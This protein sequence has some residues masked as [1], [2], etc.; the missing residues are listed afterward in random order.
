[1]N[2]EQLAQNNVKLAYWMA[3]RFARQYGVDDKE[4]EA[5][6]LAGLTAAA[7]AYDP[8]RGAK[9]S[10]VAGPYIRNALRRLVKPIQGQRLGRVDLD[11]S[12]GD[13]EGGEDASMHDVVAGGGPS[14]D[15]ER[16]DVFDKV[17]QELAALPDDERQLV[18]RWIAGET[19]R[20][21][22][23]DAGVSFVQVGNI[24][25][26]AIGKLKTQLAGKGITGMD[27]LATEALVK[28]LMG[29]MVAE[30][31]LEVGRTSPPARVGMPTVP[32]MERDRIARIK[33][34]R[35]LQRLTGDTREP[36]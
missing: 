25:R 13:E 9:F 14:T 29:R 26:K 7:N 28:K 24:I 12:F 10:S 8:A 5:Q 20:D 18:S 17:Q 32:E 21:I 6:A 2:P 31:R 15:T 22:A 34:R 1:M 23:D 4:A 16:E 33:R 27:A 3:S 19:Y 35:K 30:S 11:A 36:R